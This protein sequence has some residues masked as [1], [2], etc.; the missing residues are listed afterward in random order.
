MNCQT[1]FQGLE[2]KGDIQLEIVVDSFVSQVVEE[3]TWT[4]TDTKFG[5]VD[6]HF[7]SSRATV[8]YQVKGDRLCSTFHGEVSA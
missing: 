3:A 2:I 4:V 5:A 7:G 8:H 6:D 1:Q